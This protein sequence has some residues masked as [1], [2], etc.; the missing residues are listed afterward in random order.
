MSG[1]AKPMH[2]KIAAISEVSIEEANAVRLRFLDSDRHE[3]I[4]NLP[5][6]VLDAYL[7][8]VSRD[9][10]L[11]LRAETLDDHARISVP[12]LAWQFFR[13]PSNREPT[14]VWRTSDGRGL[15][16]GFNIDTL[17]ATPTVQVT[18]AAD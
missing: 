13:D 5:L 9:H 14:F 1:T 17:T 3:W 2:L 15:E 8:H 4:V 6:A 18:L 12:K 10:E 11:V 16:V 7:G